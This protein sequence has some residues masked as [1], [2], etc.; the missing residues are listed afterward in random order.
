MWTSTSVRNARAGARAAQRQILP[1]GTAGVTVR[2]QEGA[3]SLGRSRAS[4]SRRPT[5]R[6]SVACLPCVRF[7]LARARHAGR[8]AGRPGSPTITPPSLADTR[9]RPGCALSAQAHAA[10]ACAVAHRAARPAVFFG[11]TSQR[12][13][14]EA[15][16]RAHAC[17]AWRGWPP[18]RPVRDK[19]WNQCALVPR[20][21]T[22]M[23]ARG[24]GRCG[25]QQVVGSP[26]RAPARFLGRDR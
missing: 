22:H 20:E 5:T 13:G 17:I 3:A 8:Q 4:R 11:G 12:A 1:A 24:R 7:A 19:G 6:R 18:L 14:G 9:R 2:A 16:A 26:A 10:W 25:S 21:R 23:R 15:D